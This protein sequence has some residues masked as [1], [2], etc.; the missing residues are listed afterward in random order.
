ML[1]MHHKH[2]PNMTTV[3]TTTRIHRSKDVRSAHEINTTMKIVQD[4]FPWTVFANIL[5]KEATA[6]NIGRYQ[7]IKHL[8]ST[9]LNS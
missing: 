1:L 9:L 4:V 8:S 7:Y 5:R 2:M 3:I 6:V